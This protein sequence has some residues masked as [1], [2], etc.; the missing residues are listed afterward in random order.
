MNKT[1]TIL[2]SAEAMGV[3]RAREIEMSPEKKIIYL[4]VDRK[5][6]TEKFA[7]ETSEFW[8]IYRP[9]PKENTNEEPTNKTI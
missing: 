2:P 4:A 9:E 6:E 1:L 7:S 3:I 8:L 5:K